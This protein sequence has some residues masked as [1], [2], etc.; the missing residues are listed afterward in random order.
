MLSCFSTSLQTG[1]AFHKEL[2]YYDA[3]SPL[4]LVYPF[5]K[6]IDILYFVSFV[7]HSA[8]QN[9]GFIATTQPITQNNLK[10]TF[11][12]VVLLSVEKLT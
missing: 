12:G 5:Q 4:I 3:F 8:E 10:T 2:K 11:V 7:F 1:G 6:C 9:K